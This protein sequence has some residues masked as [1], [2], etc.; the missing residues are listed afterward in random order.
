M[1]P[2]TEHLD[3]GGDRT[4]MKN[5]SDVDRQNETARVLLDRLY[6]ERS[7]SF[8]EL[9]LLAD[10][11]G[12]GKTFVALAV[13]YSVL[14]AQENQRALSDCYQKVLVLVPQNEEL[15]RK[16]HRETSEIVKRCARPGYEAAAQELFKSKIVDRP[17]E[18][19]AT[20]CTGNERIVI[21]K[22]SALGA[23]VKEQDA[24]AKLSLAALFSHFG[25]ALPLDARARLLRAAPE[26]WS[27]DPEWLGRSV[28]DEEL[29][30]ARETVERAIRGAAAGVLRAESEKLLHD[31]REWAAPSVRGRDQGFEEIRKKTLQFYKLALWTLLE[32]ELPLVIVDEAHHWKNKRNDFSAFAR[33]VAPRAQRALL[34]TATPFQ[35]H[36]AE[37]LTLLEVGDSLSISEDRRHR[38]LELRQRVI[39]PALERAREKSNAFAEQWSALGARLDTVALRDAWHS[40]VLEAAREQLATLAHAEGALEEQQVEGVIGGVRGHIPPELREF[41]SHALRLYAFNRELGAELGR[42]VVRH[43]RS[44]HHRLVRAGQEIDHLPELLKKRPDAHVLHAAPGLDVRGDDELPLYLLMRA[45]SELESGRRTANLGSSLTGCYSTFFESAVS[46]AFEKAGEA[47]KA[48]AYAQLLKELV[49]GSDADAR[50]PKMRRI[51]REVVERWERGEKS[52]VFT[53]RVNTAE[54]LNAL[55]AEEIERRLEAR[56]NSAFGGEGGIA[57]LRQRLSTKTE[58]LYQPMLDRVLWSMLW[59]PPDSGEPPVKSTDL[60]PI[61]GDYHEI[62]RLALSYEEDVLGKADRVF[63]HRAAEHSLARR[64]LDRAPQRSRL[65]AVLERMANESWVEQAYGGVT[66]EQDATHDDLADERGVQSVYQRQRTPHADE[67]AQLAQELIARDARAKRS[68]QRGILRQAFVGPSFWLGADPEGELIVREDHPADVEVDRSDQRFL[69]V[70]LRELTF[71]QNGEL[72]FR[73]RAMAFKAMRRAMLR[74]AILVRLLPKYEER[75]DEHWAKLLVQHFTQPVE[76]RSES[77][78]R[79]V[80]VFVEDLAAASGAID[81]PF[82]ARGS[83]YFATKNRETVTIVKGDTENATRSRRFQGFNTPLLPE[84]LICGQIA[85]EGI[86][87]HRHCS[88]VV[89]YDL[90]WNPA[91]LE[92]R[93]G[94]VDRIGS[95]TQRLRQLGSG[96][97]QAEIGLAAD[98]RL[99]VNAPYLAGTYDERMFEELRLRAQTFEVLLGGDL[100]ASRPEP[101]SPDKSS[102]QTEADAQETEGEPCAVGLIALPDRMADSLRVDLAVWKEP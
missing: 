27:K 2:L 80:G 59:A 13:A 41:V 88:H 23:Q 70:H 25:R 56:R 34:L 101:P 75:E 73:T 83:L 37:V 89:H 11:V 66:A 54:R 38:L 85:Q 100:S 8:V 22:T 65:R 82:S 72:D 90:A 81:D 64:M 7:P 16:W 99:E 51:V 47:G 53:W 63:L 17:D 57:R 84:V 18:L 6:N 67:V 42:F 4:R 14:A 96:Q 87:L 20:L 48:G 12:M 95:R 102:T 39:R 91:T 60:R 93:T 79:L 3:L 86:D 76:G 5:R 26:G 10:E 35:L 62:A 31:C 9:Q 97:S 61:L 36:P 46:K 30:L 1:I 33:Y 21:A 19:V 40:A 28:K 24:K 55:I 68:G 43:R 15:R 77:M 58:A 69:H 78:L 50:H 29:P 71:D 74:E 45:T 44:T 94:R 32:R 92:Q 49:Q 52:L 98:A